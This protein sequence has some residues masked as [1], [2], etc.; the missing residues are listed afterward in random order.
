MADTADRHDLYQR[1]VQCVEDEVAFI[2][3]RFREIRGRE[4]RSVRE[5]FC[6]T[7]AMACAWAAHAPN[8]TAVGVDIDPEVLAWGRAHNLAALPEDARGRV[9]LIEGD[10]LTVQTEPVDAIAAM[11]FSY[12]LFMDRPTLLAYFRS[13]RAALKPD[14]LLFLDA[15]GGYEAHQVIEE[16]RDCE[17]F[18]YIWDQA[19]FD[20]I[21]HRMQCYIH[22][23]F[24][25]KSKMERAFSYVWR[26]W[27]LP[28]LKELLLEAGFTEVQFWWEGADEDGDGNGVFERVERGDA[29]AGWICYLIAAV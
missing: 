25:D 17:G 8:A 21:T 9:T 14:G 3:E 2:D 13:L 28:E 4:A 29:D 11:N 20:P 26:L 1:S 16:E 12:W 19:D 7:A 23:H 18:T 15:Y 6:G 22:F 24:P 10:V 5:D 27:S